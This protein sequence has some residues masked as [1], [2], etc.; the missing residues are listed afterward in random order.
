MRIFMNEKEQLKKVV[1]EACIKGKI[2]VK[3][4][5]NR[6]NFTERYVKKL[7][8]NYRKYGQKIFI[9]GNCGKQSALAIS[10]KIK[11][12]IVAL[13]QADVYEEA[14]FTHFTELLE[15]DFF[16]I[17]PIHANS[18]Q[19]KGRVEKLWG[20]LHDR[21][22]VEFNKYNIR[23]I[24]DANAYLEDFI[25]RYNNRFSIKPK[26][27]KTAFV[28]LPKGINLDLVLTAKLTRTPDVSNTISINSQKFRIECN[29]I[30]HKKKIEILIS[31]KIGVKASYNG[32]LY[33]LTPI[34]ERQNALKINNSNSTENILQQYIFFF[35]FRSV[36]EQLP[37]TY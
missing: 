21:L 3:Q 7:K 15:L 35:C 20:T 24:D 37:I 18:A 9:H 22:R 13:K 14:N 16:G 1:I 19:A 2:T 36:K 25:K 8:Q 29:E 30:L 12:K 28:A 10:A 27:K 6:L 26:L 4:A 32:K 34:L 11:S 31:K 23:N 33:P 5:S 17:E